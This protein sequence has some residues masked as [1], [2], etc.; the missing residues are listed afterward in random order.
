MSF[1]APRSASHFGHVVVVQKLGL[2][3]VPLD[4]DPRPIGS[5]DG[6][7]IGRAV[8]PRNAVADFQSF[9]LFGC[10]ES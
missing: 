7:L 5:D 8:M 3:V 1:G 9:G 4:L 6:A 10:H 2:A